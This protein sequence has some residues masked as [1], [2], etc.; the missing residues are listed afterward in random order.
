[1]LQELIL[2][3]VAK[4]QHGPEPHSRFSA[5]QRISEDPVLTVCRTHASNVHT[6]TSHGGAELVSRRRTRHVPSD[7]R[8]FA[9]ASQAAHLPLARSLD[10]LLKLRVDHRADRRGV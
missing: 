1:M 7:E 10:H 5:L 3:L 9:F 6:L 4:D 2:L 8:S